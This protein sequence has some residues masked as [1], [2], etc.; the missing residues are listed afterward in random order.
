MI[1]FLIMHKTKWMLTINNAGGWGLEGRTL[2]M[3]FWY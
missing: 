2:V 1:V 3:Q